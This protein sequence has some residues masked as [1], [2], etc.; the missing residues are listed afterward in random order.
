MTKHIA[1]DHPI[2]HDNFSRRNFLAGATAAAAGL[3]IVEPRQVAA[4]EAN[5]KITLG[6]I[7]CG[8]R[9]NWIADLFQQ[10]GGYQ[11][12]ATADYFPDRAKAA[13]QRL[14]AG[15][16]PRLQRPLGLQ[17]AAGRQAGRHRH[18]KP[19]LLPCRAGHGRRRCRLPRLLRQAD[20]RRRARLPD[21]GRSGPQRDREETRAC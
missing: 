12:V 15:R 7:G 21:D 17:A 18:R 3:L 16:K 8:G 14:G 20:R 6:L 2:R 1:Q 11:F 9:G 5:S 4:A 19:A 13:A 10:H